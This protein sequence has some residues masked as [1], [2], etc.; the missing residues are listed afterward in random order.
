MRRWAIIL[1]T[2]LSLLLC[3]TTA[4]L[5]VRS[6]W[7]CDAVVRTEHFVEADRSARLE[8]QILIAYRG[9]LAWVRVTQGYNAPLSS[10]PP[11]KS[12]SYK[13]WRPTN[14]GTVLDT[15]EWWLGF[16][17]NRNALARSSPADALAFERVPAW[18]VALLFAIA[19]AVG[20]RRWWRRKRFPAGA[21]Q[22]CGYDLRATPDRC[23][24][25]GAVAEG[26]R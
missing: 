9:R 21:C 10:Q 22:V 1:L 7:T 5:A 18:F 24:E 3:F 15:G 4:T 6:Y 23:P 19:P 8:Q 20:L 2:M 13:A 14:V 25:C 12:W 17:R 26:A 16:G 11:Q